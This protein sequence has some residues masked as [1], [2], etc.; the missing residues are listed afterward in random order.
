MIMGIAL[1]TF[2]K[3]DNLGSDFVWLISDMTNALMAIPNLIALVILSGQLVKIVK[4]YFDR[5][6]GLD[7]APLISADLSDDI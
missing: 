2:F 5:K 7:V 3:G 4:N 1:L 6:K